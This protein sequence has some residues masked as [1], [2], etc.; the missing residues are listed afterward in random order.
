M[1]G[2]YV[3][4]YDLKEFCEEYN[5]VLEFKN[6]EPNEWFIYH[7]SNNRLVPWIVGSLVKSLGIYDPRN[8]RILRRVN[9]G[10]L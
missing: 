2:L 4:K 9:I 8:Q 6:V 10:R 1:R 3:K 7:P 5:P